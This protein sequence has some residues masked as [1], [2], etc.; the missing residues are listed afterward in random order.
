GN[1]DPTH[2][3]GDRDVSC[4]YRMLEM[5]R[6]VKW[7]TA[8][9]RHESLIHQKF[10]YLPIGFGGYEIL[11]GLP[12]TAFIDAAKHQLNILETCPVG[13]TGR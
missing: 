13:E 4:A 6:V 5:G 12:H 3:V 9:G 2:I 7:F 1:G 10:R 11:K 8:H